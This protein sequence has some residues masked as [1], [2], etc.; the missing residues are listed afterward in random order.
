MSDSPQS[1]PQLT[2]EEI[3]A[4][5]I[6]GQQAQ[7][8]KLQLINLEQYPYRL[9]EQIVGTFSRDDLRK[10]MQAPEIDAN[11]KQLRRISKYLY[12]VSSQYKLSCDHFASMLTLAHIVEPRNLNPKKINKKTFETQF[13]NMVNQVDMMNIQ[14]EFSKILQVVY[15]E[16]VYCG[17]VHQNKESFFFQQLDN[18]FT[19]ITYVEDGLYFLSFNLTYFFT[20]PERLKMYP[21]EFADAYNE[22]KGSIKRKNSFFWYEL[23]PTNVIVIKTDETNWNFLPPFVSTF[24]SAL[25]IADFKALD[26]AETELGNSRLLF[27]KIPVDETSGEENKFLITPDYAQTF[28]NN[29]QANLPRQ[30]GLITSP[31]EI[32]DISFDRDSVDRNKVNEAT[33]QYWSDAGISQLLFSSNGKTTGAS[34]AKAIQAD[35]A[36]VFIILYSIERWINKYLLR[37]AGGNNFR[38]RMLKT[39]VFNVDDFIDTQV[40]LATIGIPNKQVINAASGG[41]ASTIYANA[42]LENIILDLTNTLQPALSSHVQSGK[43]GQGGAPASK[44]PTDAAQV[45]QDANSNNSD[46]RV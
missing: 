22:V 37:F 12:N 14:H 6:R 8:Q 26:K 10:Y 1:K 27:Q 11:Q 2:E 23:E 44:N 4:N 13:Y 39:T 41:K 28:H 9:K 32:T 45:T 29:I 38:V 42:Y 7:F 25:N 16:G 31:M 36:K 20:Y 24:E 19:K 46:A 34:L 35:E 33:M 18:D 5:F 3:K 43:D 21:Q 30:A 17:Y 15:R 40:S